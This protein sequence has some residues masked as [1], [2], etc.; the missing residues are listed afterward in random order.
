MRIVAGCNVF[1]EH[2][3]H[4]SQREEKGRMDIPPQVHL[5]GGAY[6]IIKS[7]ETFGVPKK[8]L[9]LL[10]STSIDESSHRLATGLLLQK[11]KFS[12]TLFPVRPRA[13]TSYY[14][15]PSEGKTWAFG[16]TGGEFRSIHKSIEGVVLSEGRKADIKIFAELSRD[17][18]EIE[19]ASM[20]LKK[21]KKGQISVLIPSRKILSSPLLNKILPLCDFFAL[22]EEEAKIFWG[23]N[24]RKADLLNLKVP[25]FLLTRGPKEAW[26]KVENKIYTASPKVIKNPKFVGGAGDATVAAVVY[27]LFV[28]KKSPKE[29]LQFGMSVGR[30]TLLTPKSY[31]V[32]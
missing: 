29:A 21:Y 8:N 13:S 26:L 9:S 11:E 24:P 14:L 5:G 32:N 17:S 20:F 1:L 25:S 23:K 30:R 28:Q 19:V 12:K 7:F 10:A 27:K 18:E 31:F 6:N 22:N 4:Y 2:I 3:L 16:D 15:L